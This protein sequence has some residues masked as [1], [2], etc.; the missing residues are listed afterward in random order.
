[1]DELE[2]YL[3]GT[4]EA[5]PLVGIA[6]IPSAGALAAKKYPNVPGLSGVGA[7]DASDLNY[8]PTSL[9]PTPESQKAYAAIMPD[10]AAKDGWTPRGFE[11]TPFDE[12]TVLQ[13][14]AAQRSN[15]MP[16]VSPARSPGHISEA[17]RGAVDALFCR[18]ADSVAALFFG[19]RARG[20]LPRVAPTVRRP[21]VTTKGIRGMD[22]ATR[23]VAMDAA[24]RSDKEWL[25][26]EGYMTSKGVEVPYR[27]YWDAGLRIFRLVRQN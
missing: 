26:A 6:S 11:Q 8:E 4:A 22:A 24:K 21:N 2:A 14:G 16:H 15:E 18:L 27:G 1:M 3:N 20:G 23:R 7:A 10:A 5:A 9:P 19:I 25:E 12:T 13:R 17:R